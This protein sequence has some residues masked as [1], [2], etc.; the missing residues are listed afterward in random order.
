[1]KAEFEGQSAECTAKV[2]NSQ[3]EPP[4]SFQLDV[5]PIFSKAGCNTGGCHGAARGKDG[6]RLS[7]FGFD[8]DGDY[9]RITREMPGRRLNLARP[10]KSLLVEKALGNVE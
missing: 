7:L 9:H 5:M 1:I 4:L 8:P 3:V 6:F 2:Q 10:E